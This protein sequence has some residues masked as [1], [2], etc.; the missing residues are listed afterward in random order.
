MCTTRE[1]DSVLLP[2]AA[3]PLA[4]PVTAGAHYWLVHQQ[5]HHSLLVDLPPLQV[6]LV[7]GDS[8]RVCYFLGYLGVSC[9]PEAAHQMKDIHKMCSP[10]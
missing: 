2:A 6:D 9:T 8:S 7:S 10:M 3:A 1:F 4:G 5:E